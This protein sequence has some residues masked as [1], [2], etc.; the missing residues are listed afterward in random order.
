MVPSI[1]QYTRGQQRVGMCWSAEPL[2]A[3]LLLRCEMKQLKQ[4][5]QMTLQFQQ[6]V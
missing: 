6:V 2:V 3:A 5:N 4:F 1:G